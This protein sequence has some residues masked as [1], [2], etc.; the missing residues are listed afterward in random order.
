MFSPLRRL[1][2]RLSFVPRPAPRNRRLLALEILEDRLCPSTD[3]W[4]GGGGN[5][6]WSNPL[7]WQ[8]HVAPKAGD[9]LE[10]AAAPASAKASYNDYAAGTVFNSIQFQAGGYDITGNAVQLQN[11]IQ[12]VS[13][14]NTVA[15]PITLAAAQTFSD[16]GGATLD[17]TAP[18]NN[19]GYLLT[20]NSDG[21]IIYSGPAICGS[22]GLTM[23][24]TAKFFL[25]D[26]TPDTYTG[27]TTVISG[28][29]YLDGV[30][31]NAIVGDLV[32]GD[33]VG[34]NELAVVREAA[35]N[36]I[37][38]GSAVFTTWTGLLDLNGFN[39]TIGPLTMTGGN[40]TT[41]TGT[42]TLADGLTTLASSHTAVIAGNLSLG[43]GT[44][45]QTFNVAS[46]STTGNDLNVTAVVSGGPGVELIKAGAGAMQLTGNGM[47]NTYLGST[48]V[49][50]GTLV[51]AN[52]EALGA[53]SAGTTVNSGATLVYQDPNADSSYT[54]AAE[55]LTLDG[56]TLLVNGNAPIVTAPGQLTLAAD[57][58]IEVNAGTTLDLTGL[59]TGPGGLTK[60][61]A[62]ELDLG[63]A[64]NY[65]GATVVSN[66]VLALDN[67]QALGA[68]SVKVSGPSEVVLKNGQTY[69]DALQCCRERCSATAARRGPAP[70][71]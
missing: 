17:L 25:E 5:A 21:N 52:A 31:G 36:Q 18:L 16:D 37:A 7:N 40:V 19:G 30:Q 69:T 10:F 70:S 44:T 29:M 59:V 54:F 6:N 27:V 33:G 24:G 38:D 42:L 55:P 1:L 47:G 12:N 13:G 39:D 8:A 34:S 4:I 58:T 67:A 62:G 57:S 43:T 56:G 64:N 14:F 23:T 68:S 2:D 63:H 3:I 48:L 41:G 9:I 49:S 66:G 53:A 22:G 45:P 26:A 46:G 35:S 28:T 60:A 61:W 11:G 71:A 15:L 50:A 51:A 65:S 20:V 32:L